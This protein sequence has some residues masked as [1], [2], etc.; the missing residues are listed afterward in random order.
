MP[1]ERVN[2]LKVYYEV[3]GE[4]DAIILM[5]HGFGCTKIWNTIYPSFVAEVTKSSCL[6]AGG[7]DDQSR[8]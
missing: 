8:G 4:G 3:R 7:L 1:F 5:H 6:T 2:N